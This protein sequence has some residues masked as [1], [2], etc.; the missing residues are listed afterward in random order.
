MPKEMNEGEEGSQRL[1]DEVMREKKMD[2]ELMKLIKA[3]IT[4]YPYISL[5]LT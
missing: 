4:K 2:A 1:D 5:I 3:A